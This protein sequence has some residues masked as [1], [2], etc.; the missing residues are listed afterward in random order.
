VRQQSVGPLATLERIDDA[1]RAL[2]L[3][4]VIYDL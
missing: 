1:P 3:P 2:L 4:D